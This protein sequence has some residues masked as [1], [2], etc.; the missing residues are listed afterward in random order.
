[1]NTETKSIWLPQAIVIAMLMAAPFLMDYSAYFGL[2]KLV[3]CPV[4]AYLAYHAWKL[5]KTGWVWV[6]GI[7][8]VI[9]NPIIRV[10]SIWEMSLLVVLASIGIAFASL[11]VLNSNNPEK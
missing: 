10:Y 5:K 7:T 1:M 4:F 8:A 6:L 2:L 11:F 9:F 3:C